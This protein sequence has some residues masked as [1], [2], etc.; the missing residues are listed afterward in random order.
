MIYPT[1]KQLRD[2]FDVSIPVAFLKNQP[3]RI[4]LSDKVKI[5]RINYDTKKNML[6]IY[7]IVM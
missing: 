4:K 7:L 5:V 2:S 6:L 1:Y 3:K